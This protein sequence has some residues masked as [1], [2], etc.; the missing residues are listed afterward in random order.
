MSVNIETRVVDRGNDEYVDDAWR[1]KENIREAD[2]VLRQRRGFFRSAY[3]RSTVYLYL[4]RSSDRLVGFAAVRRDGYILFLAVD[5]D[6]RGHGFGKRLV[7]RVAED[8]GSVTCHARSTNE[9]A[10]GFYKH[11]GFEIRRRIDN[12]Y[13]DGGDAYYLKLG[14]DSITDKLSKFLRG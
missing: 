13:E 7:A 4:D 2:G 3:R 8:Y 14:D 5:D 9:G 1:L 10:L 11:I 12:Y 6:Y